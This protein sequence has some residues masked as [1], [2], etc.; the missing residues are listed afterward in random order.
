[1]AIDQL[2]PSF[3]VMSP[4]LFPFAVDDT[5]I[6]SVGGQLSPARKS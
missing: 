4:P 1:M 2:I 3:T 5:M 6:E